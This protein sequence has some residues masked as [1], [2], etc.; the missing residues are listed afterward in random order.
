MIFVPII[1]SMH[2]QTEIRRFIP[3]FTISVILINSV[4]FIRTVFVRFPG[5]VKT[6]DL[7]F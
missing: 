2:I 5:L 7:V 4:F 6:D 3:K 1:A